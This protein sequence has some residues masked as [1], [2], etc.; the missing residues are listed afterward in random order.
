MLDGTNEK[1]ET[2]YWGNGF[3]EQIQ[4]VCDCINNNLKE[5]PI[6][7]PDQ[8]LFITKQMDEIRKDIGVIYPQ[9]N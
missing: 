2:K 8:T 3:E 4:H 5:S 6:V 1:I 9:D 7:T